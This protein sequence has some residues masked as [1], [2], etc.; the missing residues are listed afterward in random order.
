MVPLVSESLKVFSW[1]LGKGYSPLEDVH[2]TPY[3]EID[4]PPKSQRL[5]AMSPDAPN[6]LYLVGGAARY[7]LAA[8]WKLSFDFAAG[9]MFVR[10]NAI[11][12]ASALQTDPAESSGDNMFIWR[13]GLALDY[14]PSKVYRFTASLGVNHLGQSQ[15]INLS[16]P[17]TNEPVE[18]VLRLGM[19]YRF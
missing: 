17:L 1:R 4:T 3:L 2:L 5:L 13:S 11:T 12:S 10:N 8:N 16:Q 9:A 6:G 14:A 7:A 18:G 15:L 19:A